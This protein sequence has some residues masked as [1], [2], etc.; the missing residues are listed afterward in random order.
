MANWGELIITSLSSGTVVAVVNHYL[1][2]SRRKK[3]IIFENK[4]TLIR[5]KM[6]NFYDINRDLN[7]FVISISNIEDCMTDY[8]AYSSNA[9]NEKLRE[10][11]E[12]MKEV[13][14]SSQEKMKNSFKNLDSNL[15][16]FPKTQDSINVV[17]LGGRL[18][19]IIEDFQELKRINKL[20]FEESDTQVENKIFANLLMS[21]SNFLNACE[22]IMDELNREGNEIYNYLDGEK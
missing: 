22:T 8:Q 1:Q 5:E 16:F 7:E 2:L 12:N 4:S 9:N 13:I 10:K 11:F 20:P 21:C 15:V 6:K 19:S 17:N 18:V 14:G 3:E